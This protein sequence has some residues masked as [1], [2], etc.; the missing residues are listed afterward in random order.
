MKLNLIFDV[1]EGSLYSV[2]Y[3][4]QITHE[5]AR[6]MQ[7]WN[8]PLYLREYFNEHKADLNRAYWRGISI[9]EAIRKTRNHAIQLEEELL[10]L[11]K[12]GEFDKQENLSKIFE[13]LTK[14]NFEE[15]ERDKVKPDEHPSWIRIYAI[16]LGRNLFV[17]SG[18]AIKLTHRMEPPHLKQEIK[19]LNYVRSYLMNEENPNLEFVEIYK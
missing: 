10:H 18:G 6:C 8:D 2:Q 17:I 7:L 16:R 11:A 1:I 12:L 19:K 14:N 13:P 15:F 5:L 4:G 9:D 3:Q